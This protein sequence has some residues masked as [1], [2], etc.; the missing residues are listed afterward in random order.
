M[1]FLLSP[2]GA[3]QTI[4]SFYF[5]SDI[6]VSVETYIRVYSMLC[7]PKIHFD[8]LWGHH[9]AFQIFFI[10]LSEHE[11]MYN[12]INEFSC[13]FSFDF[14][15]FHINV[16][17]CNANADERINEAMSQLHKIMMIEFL[18]QIQIRLRKKSWMIFSFV[19][20]IKN[21]SNNYSMQQWLKQ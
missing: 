20:K 4:C 11:N 13:L 6:T 7:W 5:L 17:R 12:N 19:V 8:L 9:I 10:I 1:M 3:H 18:Y 14:I 15:S 16:E 21:N 2:S